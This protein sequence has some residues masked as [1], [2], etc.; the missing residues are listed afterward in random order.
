MHYSSHYKRKISVL[1]NEVSRL[2]SRVCEEQAI[3]ADL[4]K[5]LKNL[6]RKFRSCMEEVKQLREESFSLRSELRL[7]KMRNEELSRELERKKELET[8][9]VEIQKR[10]RELKK[11]LNLRRGDEEVFGW[12]TPSSKKVF[13]EN[14]TE[15]NQSKKGGGQ[16]G[17]KGRTAPMFLHAVR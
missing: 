2:E 17:H 11:K 16:P 9:F 4:F 7:A 12:S 3:N 8:A 10:N 15:E 6:E 5:C 14:S 1:E 13:K